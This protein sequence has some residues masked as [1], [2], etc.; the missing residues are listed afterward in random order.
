MVIPG[1]IEADNLAINPDN[2]L[3]A[4][5]W[6]ATYNGIFRTNAVIINIDQ[7]NDYAASEKDQYIGEAKFIRALLYFNMVRLYGGVPK[8]TSHIS[9]ADAMNIPKDSEEEIYNLVI[10]DLKDAISKLPPQSGISRG[11]AHKAAAV[12]LLA[13]VYVFRK[14]WTNAKTYL[15]QLF[16]EFN[17]SLLTDFNKVFK[18]EDHSEMI[19]A[20]KYLEG[21]NGQSITSGY[22]HHTGIYQIGNG[23]GWLQPAWSVHK[24]FESGD[25]RKEASITE[26]WKPYNAQET[27]PYDWYPYVN[28]F[29]IS[30]M[31]G[32]AS[33]L[34]LP[35]LRLGEMILLYSEVLYELQ[36]PDQALFQ[37]N[38]IRERAFG[39]TSHNYTLA[40]IPDRNAF[41]EKLILER[42]LELAFENERWFDLVRF[43]IF[44]STMAQY[45][46]EYNNVTQTAVVKTLS[47]AAY[48]QKLPIPQRQI[49]Q[50]NSGILIQN[51]GY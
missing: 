24:L 17:Y 9:I 41:M 5:Y 11:R 34:D 50:S 47:P 40:D 8:I 51:D 36:Q 20:I 49:E 31:S 12:A 28:K 7:P 16:S 1:S 22:S 10:E 33:G 18:T 44:V 26:M 32:L 46:T 42:R 29:M 27:D 19:F 39:D 45:E 14:D 2:D 23:G 30:F 38:R 43:G 4:S 13:K 35:V 15:E 48:M 21:T 25:T 3:V 37:L 6:E